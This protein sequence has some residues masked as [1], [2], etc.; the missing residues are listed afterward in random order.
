MTGEP[1]ASIAVCDFPLPALCVPA[2]M[3]TC[4]PAPIGC[5]RCCNR[6]SQCPQSRLNFFAKLHAASN[7]Q[8]AAAAAAARG[9]H[10]AWLQQNL[11]RVCGG[12]PTVN[13]WRVPARGHRTVADSN[14]KSQGVASAPVPDTLQL[15]YSCNSHG[16]LPAACGS[17]R[18][19]SAHYSTVTTVLQRLTQY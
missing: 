2:T 8:A 10:F 1:D 6:T 15:T 9:L 7:W 12:G 19:Q 4:V 13:L 11:M 17:A 18:R 16:Q 14:C 3:V 5:N